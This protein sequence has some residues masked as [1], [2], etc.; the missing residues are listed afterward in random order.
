L[1]TLTSHGGVASAACRVVNPGGLKLV[2]LPAYPPPCA[3]CH[4]LLQV[5]DK[6]LTEVHFC[7]LYSQLCFVLQKKLPE[8]EDPGEEAGGGGGGQT[9]QGFVL[10]PRDDWDVCLQKQLLRFEDVSE[11]AQEVGGAR[12]WVRCITFTYVW[13]LTVNACRAQ[14]AALRAQL[15]VAL[16]VSIHSR[17][18]APEQEQ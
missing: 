15:S 11:G 14:V 16:V 10:F 18:T 17:A 9:R 13:L 4:P 8:F 3:L 6:A 7:E 5:F 1:R 2:Y 12:V